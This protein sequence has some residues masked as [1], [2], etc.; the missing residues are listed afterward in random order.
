MD[1]VTLHDRGEKQRQA[2]E[3]QGI[4]LRRQKIIEQN[5]KLKSAGKALA[6]SVYTCQTHV[7]RRRLI[8]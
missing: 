3:Q 5:K 2:R 7:K 6:V 8:C 4:E 1:E